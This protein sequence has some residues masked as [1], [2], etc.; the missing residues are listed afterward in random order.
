MN[1]AGEGDD[2]ACR[3]PEVS[4]DS[5]DLSDFD[6]EAAVG[7]VGGCRRPSLLDTWKAHPNFRIG[8]RLAELATMWHVNGWSKELFPRFM[9]W[10]REQFPFSVGD[11]NHS[12]RFVTSFLPS[13][14]FWQLVLVSGSLKKSKHPNGFLWRTFPRVA[15]PSMKEKE[16]LDC[17]KKKINRNCR[18]AYIS[19]LQANC[20]LY[21]I[22]IF[23]VVMA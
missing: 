3:L 7:A 15:Q 23:L 10:A 8:L 13:R 22:V 4:S 14:H 18:T 9:L 2:G 5:V 12:E 16:T 20:M 17:S 21:C 11:I 19:K 1:A 6:A